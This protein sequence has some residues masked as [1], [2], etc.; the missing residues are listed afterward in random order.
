MS[1]EYGIG[2]HVA[3]LFVTQTYEGQSDIHGKSYQSNIFS[4]RLTD[5]L[6]LILGRAITGMQAFC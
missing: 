6:A 3:N 5:A 2:R 1:D 4:H